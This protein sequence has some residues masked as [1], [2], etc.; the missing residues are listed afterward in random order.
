MYNCQ[1]GVIGV[2]I[3][4]MSAWNEDSGVSTHAELIGREWVRMGHDLKVFSFFTHDFH[5]TAIVGKDEDYV[6]RCFTTSGA[7]S[8]Y[9]DPRPILEADFEIFIAQ[10]LGMLPKDCLGRIFHH[11]QRK[12]STLTV[13]HDNRPSEDPSFYQFDWDRIVCF[14]WRYEEFL[15]KYHPEEK[16]CLIPFPCMPLRRGDKEAARAK[17]GLPQDKKIILIFGQRLKEHLPVLSLIREVNRQVP[18][19]LLVVSQK[20]LEVLQGIGK[21]QMVIRRESPSI[22]RLYDYLHASDVLVVHR[23]PHNGV[24][25]SSMAYQCLGSGCPILAS[26]TNFFETMKDVVVTYSD[27]EEFKLNVTDLLTEGERFQASQ[28]ALESFL[29]LNSAEA[30]ARQYIDLFEIMREEKRAGILPQFLGS[31]PYLRDTGQM[32]SEAVAS[33]R[34]TDLQSS[35]AKPTLKVQNILAIESRKG[36]M[37]Q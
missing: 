33:S 8:P 37:Q 18:C 19:L 22:D 26:N 5:G 23:S 25:I 13:I 4:M 9:L 17:L 35:V 7:N 28:S 31:V 30:M 14:D 3:A 2:R 36:T 11:I 6:V 34:A 1:K 29:R 16:M 21:E 15:K 24:L 27:S 20:D 32:Y 12:A 10:D